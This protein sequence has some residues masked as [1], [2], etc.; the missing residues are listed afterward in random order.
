M[1]ARKAVAHQLARACDDMMRDRVPFAVHTA[2][3]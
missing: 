2:F 3:G 1:I